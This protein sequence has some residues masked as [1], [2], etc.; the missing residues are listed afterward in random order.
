MDDD[1]KD[2]PARIAERLDRL[3]SSRFDTDSIE[4]FAS[5]D[6]HGAVLL[7]RGELY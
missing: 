6:E 7:R 2:E 1:E 3:G 4:A 5:P